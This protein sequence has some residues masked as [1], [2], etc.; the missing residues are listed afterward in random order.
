MF[1]KQTPSYQSKGAEQSP[2]AR[3]AQ[4]WDHRIGSARVQ[5]RNWRI[6]A[7][8]CLGLSVVLVVGLIYQAAQTHIE[9]YVVPIDPHGR[10][11]K[12]QLLNNTYSPTSAQIGF[13]VAR[14]IRKARSRPTDPVVLK[15]NW[16][17]VYRF[18]AGDAVATM[19]AYASHAKS[20]GAADRG[21]A[22]AVEIR[23]VVQRSDRSFQVQWKQTAYQHGVRS[24][25]TY[26][27][28]LFTTHIV[29]PK[30]EQTLMHNPLGVYVTHFSWSQEM[31]GNS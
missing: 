12:I 27:T 15:R 26:W 11:G 17:D 28:G 4:V 13:Y 18:L 25:V 31:T 24:K 3:A 6:V 8:A 5:A 19:N 10:P 9:A 1:K 29:T 16:E 7:F 2:F 22:V 30:T 21:I 14:L 20:F 23:S